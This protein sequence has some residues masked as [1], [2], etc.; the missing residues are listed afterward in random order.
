MSMFCLI[1]SGV[2]CHVLPLIQQGT[3]TCTSGFVVDSRCDYTCFQGYQIEGDRYRV[4][5]EGGAWSG[6]E[7]TCAGTATATRTVPYSLVWRHVLFNRVIIK[8]IPIKHKAE[9]E[10]C[11]GSITEICTTH[12]YMIKAGRKRGENSC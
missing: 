10:Q 5:Q 1:L 12:V 7:P 11:Y 9:T 6:A 8:N 4:C 2:R 3:Y